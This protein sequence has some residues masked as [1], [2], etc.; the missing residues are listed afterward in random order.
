MLKKMSRR[1][2]GSLAVLVTAALG[3]TAEQTQAATLFTPNSTVDIVVTPWSNWQ[4][5]TSAT[6]SNEFTVNS[7]ISVTAL[8]TG[9]PGGPPLIDAQTWAGPPTS[10]YGSLSVTV[11][12]VKLGGV[13]PEI[14]ASVNQIANFGQSIDF[15]NFSKDITPV[16]LT[17]GQYAIQTVVSV[18]RPDPVFNYFGF[19]YRP[20]IVGVDA[21][22][23]I[24]FSGS[25]LYGAN[26]EFTPLAAVPLPTAAMSG[27]ALLAGLVT[28]RRRA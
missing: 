22:D 25:S 24:T 13:S 23:E 6:L 10:S 16:A 14:L 12:L 28:S 7:P 26:A 17:S 5:N 21:A 11:N 20:A 2:L 4:W 3:A 8:K 18:D 15:G 27:G 1:A 9:V 19:R